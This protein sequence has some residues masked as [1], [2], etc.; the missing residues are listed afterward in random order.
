MGADGWVCS[1][2][3]A[4]YRTLSL[5]PCTVTANGAAGHNRGGVAETPPLARTPRRYLKFQLRWSLFMCLL[6]VLRPDNEEG[7]KNVESQAV[8]LSGSLMSSGSLHS[9][10]TTPS[11][12]ATC[13]ESPGSLWADIGAACPQSWEFSGYDRIHLRGNPQNSVNGIKGQRPKNR[14]SIVITGWKNQECHDSRL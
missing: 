4:V 8:W 5:L 9:L 14:A 13:P 12:R 1:L 7:P 10:Q 11:H 3:Y 2:V 6:R